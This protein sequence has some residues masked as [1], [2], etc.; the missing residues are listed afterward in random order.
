MPG[1]NYAIDPAT[2]DYTLDEHGQYV[3]DETARTP[4]VLALLEERGQWWGDPSQGSDIS[5]TLRGQPPADVEAAL[6][7][8]AELALAPLLA[9]GRI[10]SLAV[11][12]VAVE[13]VTI[14]VEAVDGGSRKPIT[15]TVTPLG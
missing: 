5:A 7:A 8:A 12:V 2:G 14:R 10:V 9:A 3:L 4:I 1:F 13:P 11:T 6:V 15:V